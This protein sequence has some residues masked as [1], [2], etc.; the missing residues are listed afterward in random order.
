MFLTWEPW[1]Q[2]L[3]GFKSQVQL[4]F[5][6]STVLGFFL[7]FLIECSHLR[8]RQRY[9]ISGILFVLFSFWGILITY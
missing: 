9:L 7:S 3:P 6:L 1:R 2:L 5:P 4:D 8:L